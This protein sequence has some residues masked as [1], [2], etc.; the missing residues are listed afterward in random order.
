MRKN[1]NA[2]SILKARPLTLEDMP[3]LRDMGEINNGSIFI[4]RSAKGFKLKKPVHVQTKK[5]LALGQAGLAKYI[6]Q[7]LSTTRPGLIPFVLDNQSL[8]KMANYFLRSRTGSA[9]S[10]FGYTDRIWRYSNRVEKT[11]DSLVE[12][13][14]NGNSSQK[15]ILAHTQALENFLAELQDQELS[16][17]RVSNYAKSVKTFYRTSGVSITTQP[18]S[19]RAIYPHRSPAPEELMT[20]LSHANLREK[21]IISMLALGGFR[22]GTLTKLKYSHVKTDLERGTIPL[23]V[24]VEASIAKGRYGDFDT[25]LPAEAVEF[26]KH[27]LDE[28][29]RGSPDNT[30]KR[31]KMPPEEITDDS[32]LI[33]DSQSKTPRPISEKQIYTTIHRLLFKSGLIVPGK[34]RYDLRVHS[35]RKFFKTQLISKRVPESY[36]EYFMGHVPDKYGY[37]DV[38]SQGIDVLRGIYASANMAITPRVASDREV[39]KKTLATLVRESGLNPDEIIK[40]ESL[41]EPHRAFISQEDMEDKQIGALASAFKEAVK[42]EVLK[43]LS[44]EPATIHHWYGGPAGIRTPVTTV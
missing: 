42:H 30:P 33:K 18:M 22:E 17:G 36:A 3:W 11:P 7:S 38:A 2:S 37:N 23:H 10:L 44:L 8:I 4:Q 32:P 34:K 40:W 24:H 29:R 9:G 25:F 39:L 26:L 19:R 43:E 1:K 31:I 28:R 16:P 21:V 15:K 35:F 6:I 27:Y 14:A 5:I 20:L 12:D 13:V 41:A